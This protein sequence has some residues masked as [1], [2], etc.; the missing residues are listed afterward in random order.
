MQED[1][2]HLNRFLAGSQTVGQSPMP[3]GQ[4]GQAEY[5][6]SKKPHVQEIPEQ[7]DRLESALTDTAQL[8]S[9]LHQRL[10]PVMPPSAPESTSGAAI[11]NGREP[12]SPMGNQLAGFVLFIEQN[13]IS[14]RYLL[15][16]I[17]L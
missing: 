13:N 16:R 9:N 17:K 11:G 6:E 14:L 10:S 2:C 12:S 5:C 4:F 3:R 15:D 8:L 7:I 1:A